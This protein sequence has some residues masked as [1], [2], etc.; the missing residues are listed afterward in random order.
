MLLRIE[1]LPRGGGFEFVSE[2]RGG[3]LPTAFIPA[4]EK[5]VREVLAHGA[6]AG[7]P[8]VDVRVVVLDGKHHSVDSK[9][10][11]FATAARKAFLDAILKARPVVLEPIGQIEISAPD[12]VMGDLTGDLSAKRGLVMIKGLVP[13]SELNGY[14]IRLNA[15]TGGQGRYAIALSHHEPVPPAVQQQMIQGHH[16]RD[17]E[18]RTV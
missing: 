8:V 15:L 16:A 1:P 2:V 4:V 18:R 6:V 11:A 9:E 14:Q 12:A 3:T 17:D 5:G 10:I 7:F 13:L